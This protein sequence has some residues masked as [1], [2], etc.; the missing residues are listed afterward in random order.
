MEG[1]MKRFESKVAIVTGA[2]TGIGRAVA[3]RLGGEGAAV[4]VNYVGDS[5][6]QANEVAR[7]IEARGGKALPILAD[8]SDVRQIRAMFD[9]T[10]GR[11]GRVD[12]VVNNAAW[13]FTKPIVDVTEQEFDRVFA[14]NVKGTFFG[15]QEA[16]RRIAED[17][18]IINVSSSTT[19]LTLPG[20]GT[21]DATK[22]AIEQL[23]RFLAHEIGARGVTVNTVS[24]GATE[25]EQFHAGKSDELVQRLAEMSVFKRLG[26][27]E[28]IADVIAFLASEDARW[29]T[30]QNIRVNGGTV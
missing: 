23:A 14:I 18:R 11:Y 27:V 4:A 7:E 2:A 28:D 20:Y 29:I 26:R 5:R 16:A 17:G 22:G 1:A 13:A 21:Y 9:A 25:T 19:G 8:V 12:I 6:A 3:L 10:I 24:P 30:G 15:C